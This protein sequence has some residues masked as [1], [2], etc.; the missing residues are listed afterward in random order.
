MCVAADWRRLYWWV[1]LQWVVGVATSGPCA[2]RCDCSP[3]LPLVDCSSQQLSAVPEGVPDATQVLNLTY[4]HLKTLS[5]RQFFSLRQLREL[6]L[7]A[8]MLTVIEV[9]AFVGLQNLITLRLSR[10]RLKIIPVGAF[11]GLPNVQFLDISENEILVLLDDMFG[12][13][14]SLQKL[15]ASENDLVFI[16]NRAFS[17]LPN[18]LELRLERCNLTTVPSEAFS[19]LTGLQHLR[20]CR[21]GL[22]ALPNN[23]FRQLQR[24]QDLHVSRCPWLHTLAVNSL[25]GLNLTSLTLSH[26]NLSAV[27]YAPL[28]HLVYLRYLD[29]SY[30]PIT[31]V[32]SGLLGDLLRLQELHLVSTGL[33]HVESGA[34]RNLAFFRL[35][36]VSDNRLVTLE[37]SAFH[38]V[39]SL[40]VLR[41]DGNPLAC[42]CRLLWVMRRRLRLRFAGHA[43]SCV[44]P[45]QVQGRMFQDFAESEVAR[46]FTCRQ[47]RIL[48]RKPQDVRSDEGH[49]VLFFCAADGDPA[50][51]IIWLNPKRSVLTASGRIRVLPN[52]TLEVRYAQVQDSGYYLCIASNAAGNDSISVSLRVRGFP[53]SS[54]NRSGS[55]FL[56][57]W[58]F[59]SGQTA[60]NGSQPFPFDVKTLVIAVTMGF[61]SFLSSVA[62]CFIFMFF[63]SQSKGQIKHTATIQFVPR[64]SASTTAGRSTVETGRFTMKLI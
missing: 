4:N 12:E 15:E 36:N 28:H 33:L 51:S 40:E 13:M 34:F 61:L 63:W 41:L 37:E 9:E 62:L 56:D 54:R 6:D 31:T 16:S 53:A 23:S 17:G 2:Q 55:F 32:L 58:S 27:P 45:V 5:S 21:L 18:L 52:G 60:V 22:T 64:S 59:A 47:A 25:I 30:N 49:T 26:C 3:K 19:R 35:L 10:N 43:P 29:L 57:G 7:S 44:S 48:T 14:P 11:S 46:T 42:D 50:P 1:V 39:G 8:N 24:L 20:F 38:A